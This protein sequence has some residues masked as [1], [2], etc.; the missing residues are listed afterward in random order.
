MNGWGMGSMVNSARRKRS[1]ARPTT[2]TAKPCLRAKPPKTRSTTEKYLE[3]HRGQT[4]AVATAIAVKPPSINISDEPPAEDAII[5][6]LRARLRHYYA[7]DIADS[8]PCA[9]SE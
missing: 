4:N 1:A 8:W 3:P 5:V 6:E 2:A 7:R 9:T